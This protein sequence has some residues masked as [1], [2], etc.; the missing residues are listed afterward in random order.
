MCAQQC[1]ELLCSV[2]HTICDLFYEN[3]LYCLGKNIFV[4]QCMQQLFFFLYNFSVE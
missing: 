1:F 4:L 2:V 3:R